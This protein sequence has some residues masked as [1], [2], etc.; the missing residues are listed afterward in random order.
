MVKLRRSSIGARAYLRCRCPGL[1]LEFSRCSRLLASS[2]VSP[3]ATSFPYVELHQHSYDYPLADRS[4]GHSSHSSPPCRETCQETLWP[5]MP[6]LLI[7]CVSHVTEPA[8]V[9]LDSGG[10]ADD[11][12][13]VISRSGT[14]KVVSVGWKSSGVGS[15][16]RSGS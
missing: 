11:V 9:S 6:Q 12:T 2:S 7:W 3:F 14:T 1:E 13:Q 8:S 4:C 5:T 15:M 10:L 16:G